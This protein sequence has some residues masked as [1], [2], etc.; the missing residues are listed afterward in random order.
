MGESVQLDSAVDVDDFLRGTNFLSASGGGE[1]TAERGLLLDDLDR[2]ISLTWKPLDALDPEALVCT[3]CFSGSIAPEVFGAHAE[4]DEIAAGERVARPLVAS[5][6]ALEEELGRRIEGLCSIEIGGINTA[7]V[8]DAAANLGIAMVDGDYAGRAIPELHA[9][10]L[11]LFGAQVLPW[12]SVDQYGN[13]V[14][15]RRSPSNAFAER[16]GKFLAQASFGLIGCAMAAMPARDVARMYVQGTISESLALGR[17]IRLARE[18]GTDPVAAAA[19]ALGGW[20]LFRGTITARDWRNTGYLEGTHE[21]AGDEE[22]DGRVLRVWFKNEN[23]VTWLDG[24]PYVA[25]PDMVEVCDAVTAEPLVNTYLAVGDRVAVV[26]MQRRP[27]WD[28]PDGV[29]A[30]G[31]AHFGWADIPFRGVETLVSKD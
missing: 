31:P 20:V 19:A 17:A 7:S 22:F 13:T 15:I 21:I 8:L 9:T 29:A 27:I 5:V 2:G 18:R 6:K 30:L 23:H 14:V 4:A 12:A 26:G 24:A 25:S 28:S 16:I 3:A 10:A 11:Q 1:P